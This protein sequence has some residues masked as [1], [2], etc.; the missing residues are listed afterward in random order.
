[1]T[2]LVRSDHQTRCRYKG[3]AAYYS[4]RVDGKTSQDAV[5]SYEQPLAD[6]AEIAGHV[7]FYPNRVDT[8]EELPV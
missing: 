3:D 6:V 1:M 5:W 4:I 2:V 7:A 8:I